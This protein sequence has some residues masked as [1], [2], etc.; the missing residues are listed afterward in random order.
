MKKGPAAASAMLVLLGSLA[1]P[2]TPDFGGNASAANAHVRTVK[3]AAA[4]VSTMQARPAENNA[5][6]SDS[7]AFAKEIQVAQG[8]Q[9]QALFLDPDIYGRAEENLGDVRIVNASGQFMPYYMDSGEEGERGLD[10]EYPLELIDRADGEKEIRFDFRVVQAADNEDVRG[11]R[12][13]F[14]LPQASFLK[15]VSLDGSYDGQRWEAVTTGE[16]YSTGEGAF[17]NVIELNEP[18][19]YGY[20]RVKVPKGPEPFDLEGMALIDVG[21]AVSGEDFRRTKEIPFNVESS[22]GMSEVVM[23]NADKLRIDRIKLNAAA[24]DGS[25]GFSRAFYVNR[26]KGTGAN[27]RILSPGR[28]NRLELAGST[29]DDTEIWLADPIRNEKPMVVI[30]NGENPPLDIAS[31]EIGY[32]VDRLVFED[33][34]TGPY[35]LVYGAER[36]ETPQYDISAFRTQIE[37]S[38]PGEATLGKENAS[39]FVPPAA[40]EENIS[41]TDTGDGPKVGA[42]ASLQITFNL[43]LVAVALVLIVFLG[44]KLKKK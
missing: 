13:T 42:S 33:T 15:K 30:N 4:T 40:T 1:L 24:S 5:E 23:Y 28:L 9:Y 32:R 6:A 10:R 39:Q 35:R 14:S 20:Y 19:K 16:L 43:V 44:K 38:G 26:E 12:L 11:S 7:W 18:A 34:G 25:S 2:G 17:R 29:V 8:A 41:G 31:I 3:A 36:Q 37:Q 21:T 27:T 22:S